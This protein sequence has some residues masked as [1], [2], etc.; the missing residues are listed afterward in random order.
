[1]KKTINAL[2]NKLFGLRIVNDIYY[3]NLLIDLKKQ[4]VIGIFNFF[5]KDNKIIEILLKHI[6]KSKSKEQ[7]DFFVLSTLGLKKNGVFVEFGGLDGLKGSNTYLL[8]KEFEWE[9]LIIEPS[10]QYKE[11]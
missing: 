9:G 4:K 11:K 7:Q 10:K 8:E 5:S 3:N 6:V 2:L 1:M